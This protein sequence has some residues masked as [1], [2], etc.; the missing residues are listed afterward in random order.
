MPSLIR[1]RVVLVDDKCDIRMLLRTRLSLL[2]QLDIVGEAADG[3]AAI[4]LTR[5]EL[6]DAMVLDLEMP[7]MSGAEAMPI[8]R[9]LHPPMRI[10]VYS[11]L[12]DRFSL[13]GPARPEAMLVKGVELQVL[14]DT[15]V[16]LLREKLPKR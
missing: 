2:P 9:R 13:V 16:D 11:A 5:R 1:Y 15:L 7:V 8:L 12:G 3:R 10:I 6:P 14:V 4:E